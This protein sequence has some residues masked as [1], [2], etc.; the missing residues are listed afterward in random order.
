M[1]N[2]A[3]RYYGPS[4]KIFTELCEQFSRLY[5]ESNS[6]ICNLIETVTEKMVLHVKFPS[7]K[8]KS[9]LFNFTGVANL[10]LIEIINCYFICRSS[11]DYVAKNV[12]NEKEISLACF[13][14]HL[15]ALFSVFSN[16]FGNLLDL[17]LYLT[18][19]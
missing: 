9:V 17:I 1:L 13:D 12:K 11:R 3:L 4:E 2:S 10:Y 16:E 5:L 15:L 14:N 7:R 8:D 19:R 6:D 18:F